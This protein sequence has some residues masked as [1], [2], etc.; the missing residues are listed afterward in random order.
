MAVVFYL[1]LSFDQE[2]LVNEDS[3]TPQV[4]LTLGEASAK[5]TKGLD[6]PNNGLAT[7][8]GKDI[9]YLES[10]L[11]APNRIDPSV[12][13]YDWWIYNENLSEYVQV[14]VVDKKVVS[15]YAIGPDLNI[16]P[17]S[18]GQSV[19]EIYSTIPIEPHVS[20][21]YEG[22]SYR[23]ELTEEDMNSRPLI[24]IGDFYAQV[25]IDKFDGTLSSIRFM[26]AETLILLQPY[27]MVYLGELLEVS[28]EHTGNETE[29][30]KGSARQI[31]DITNVMRMRHGLEPVDWDEP[32]AEVA[33]A[34]SIDMFESN[35][36]SHT[37]KK[38]GELADRLEAG[39]VFYQIAGENIAANYADAP[40]V[41]EGWLN[42]KGH[43]ETLLN[44][45][46]SHLGVGVYE[47][48]Y[49]QNFIQKWEQ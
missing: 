31:L 26:D 9:A 24:P 49:T 37:S 23:F 45:E 8:I 5:D 17:F 25:H 34:H 10:E 3:E 16:H 40:A 27:E 28:S 41:M 35:D 14:G 4:D 2:I 33:L 44:H 20:L 1:N 6:V 29:I 43:R 46:F 32:V 12:H 39:E 13:G 30:S 11:G 36:F 15:L 47:Q 7:F 48:H 42:S 22:S 38:Y 18:I 19:A 21:E